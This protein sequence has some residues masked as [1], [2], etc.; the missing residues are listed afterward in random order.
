[1]LRVVVV[2]VMAAMGVSSG[3]LVGPVERLK[4]D[5]APVTRGKCLGLGRGLIHNLKL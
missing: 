1:M 4:H 2:M 5:V 3:A